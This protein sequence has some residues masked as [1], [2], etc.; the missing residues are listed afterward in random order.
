MLPSEGEDYNAPPSCPNQ[1]WILHAVF[2]SQLVVVVDSKNLEFGFWKF[3][4]EYHAC[5]LI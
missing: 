5:S 4:N 3:D 1:P 2:K